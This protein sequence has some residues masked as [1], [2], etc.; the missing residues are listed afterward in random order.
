MNTIQK[1]QNQDKYISDIVIK[2]RHNL[3]VFFLYKEHK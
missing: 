3:I 1:I 2:K